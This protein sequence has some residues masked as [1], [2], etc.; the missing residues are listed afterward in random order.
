MRG[1]D[2]LESDAKVLTV[3]VIACVLSMLLLFYVL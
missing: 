2:W 3:I 1:S